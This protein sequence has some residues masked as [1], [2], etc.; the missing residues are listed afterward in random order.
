[1]NSGAVMV[2]SLWCPGRLLSLARKETFLSSRLTSPP[3]VLREWLME[4]LFL[5]PYVMGAF[6]ATME[7][8]LLILGITL[9]LFRFLRERRAED[10]LGMPARGGPDS[11]NRPGGNALG[12]VGG[13]VK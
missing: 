13:L 5:N 8:G 7:I 10:S 6:G 2:T 1:M 9:V 3:G 11:D 4:K 12:G